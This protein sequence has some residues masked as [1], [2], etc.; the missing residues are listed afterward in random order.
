MKIVPHV[1]VAEATGRSIA[2]H[3]TYLQCNKAIRHA[4]AVFAATLPVHLHK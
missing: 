2:Y 4:M 1:V 3:M